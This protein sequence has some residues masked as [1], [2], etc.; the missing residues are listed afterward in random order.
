MS[1]LFMS[2]EDVIAEMQSESL[3]NQVRRAIASDNAK[4][5]QLQAQRSP[6]GIMEIRRLEFETARRVAEILGLNLKPVNS[7]K[8]ENP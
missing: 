1:K 3:L 6:I 8:Q 7:S 2:D 5:A 4:I